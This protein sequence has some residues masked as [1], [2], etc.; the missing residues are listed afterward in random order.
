[1][2][3]HA[4]C[5]LELVGYFSEDEIETFKCNVR[6]QMMNC[7]WLAVECM[8]LYKVSNCSALSPFCLISALRNFPLFSLAQVSALCSSLSCWFNTSFNLFFFR[9]WESVLLK[10][11]CLYLKTKKSVC[12]LERWYFTNSEDLRLYCW[13][14]SPFHFLFK[15]HP[16]FHVALW[17]LS[18]DE[19]LLIC[20]DH[21]PLL[22]LTGQCVIYPSCLC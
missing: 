5:L 2:W 9:S 8:G 7:C 6:W 1:M 3:H 20:T 13:T 17:L 18:F 22:Q 16:S 21:P 10:K 12:I 11:P 14:L 15:H 4:P 19:A